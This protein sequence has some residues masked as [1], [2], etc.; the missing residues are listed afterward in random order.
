[1][2]FDF[3]IME[4]LKK[5][6]PDAEIAVQDIK[7][8][9]ISYKGLTIRENGNPLSPAINLDEYEKK[10][11]SGTPLEMIVSS[12]DSLY[13]EH[14]GDIDVVPEMTRE[15]FLAHTT[16]KLINKDKNAEKMENTPYIEWADLIAIPVYMET[17]DGTSRSIVENNA[18]LN[19]LGITPEEALEAGKKSLQPRIGSLQKVLMSILSDSEQQDLKDV[20]DMTNPNEMYILSNPSK[21]FGAASVLDTETI[22]KVCDIMDDDV[23]I[24]PSSI[25]EVLV[26]AAADHDPKELCKIVHDVNTTCVRD[27]EVLSENVY[28]FDREQKIVKTCEPEIGLTEG[29]SH[30]L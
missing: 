27:D 12:I 29:N 3:I 17:K 16:L 5:I 21:M 18:V 28:L 26:L 13:Q 1:M 4:E 9:N 25:H 14:K 19:R 15:N 30:G 20:I 6:Y 10:Y 8:T 7:K 11:E 24:I 22:A 2:K 23:F